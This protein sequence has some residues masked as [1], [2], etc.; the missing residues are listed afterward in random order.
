MLIEVWKCVE[1]RRIVWITNNNTFQTERLLDEKKK[2]NFVPIHKS[3]SIQN[4]TDYTS[5]K[6]MSYKIVDK[7]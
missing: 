1:E 2:I 6:L 3:I 7:N 5:V 4:Y